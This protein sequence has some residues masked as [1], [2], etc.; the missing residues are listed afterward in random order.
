MTEQEFKF[1]EQLIMEQ[2]RGDIR[3]FLPMTIGGIEEQ[4]IKFDIEDRRRKKKPKFEEL[5]KKIADEKAL[6]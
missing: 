6:F 5:N 1:L 2:P 4:D 3:L